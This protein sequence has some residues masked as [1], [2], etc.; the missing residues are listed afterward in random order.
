MPKT[1]STGNGFDK[2][3]FRMHPRVFAALG[4]DLVTN[5]VVAVIELVKNSYDAFAST[6]W[7]RFNKDPSEGD[8]LEI[9]DDGQGMTRKVIEEAWC[10]VAT[11]FKQNNPFVKSGKEQRRVAGQKGLG[12][13]SVARL[14][15]RLHM[16]TQAP[17]D[18]CW[19]V[20]VN[21]SDI[22][23]ENNLS[24]CF[25]SC[26]KFRETSPFKKSGTRLRVFGLRGQW[27]EPRV[28]DLEENLARLISPFSTLGDFYIFLSPPGGEESEEVKILAPDFL[29]KPKYCIRGK[30][31]K[32]GNI[33]ATYKYSPILDG[34]G[35]S[36]GQL[37]SWQQ[38]FDLIKD[39]SRHPF[40]KKR[41]RC[42]MFSFEIRAWDIGP[43]DTQE[44][45]DRFDF[46]KNKVRK[47]IKAHKGI[48]VYRDGILVLPKSEG[49]RDWLGLD[50]RRISKVG[51]RLSTSQLVGYVAISA[52]NNPRIEDTSD[53]ERLVSN[54]SVAEFEELLKKIIE[55]LENER[56]IDRA[57][58]EREKPLEDLFGQLSADKLL[59]DVSELIEEGAD[60]SDAM[61]VLR[62]YSDKLVVARNAIQERFVYYSRMA[63][64]GTIAMMLVHEIR[65]R[66]TAFGSFL[67][68]I[69]S[70]YGPFKDKE[71]K[72]EFQS[73]DESV[74]S[75]ERLA[76][77]FAPL[78]DRGFRR[79]KRHSI[80]EERIRACLR[81]EKGE[82]AQKS[83]DC[84]IPEGET[85]V[86]V[87]P[88]ELDTIIIN[89]ITNATYWL[90][91]KP[92]HKGKI[93][94][95]LSKIEGGNRIRVWVHDNGPGLDDEDK[96]KI[97]WPGFTRKPGGIG[98]GLTVSSELV[99]EYGGHMLIDTNGA[100]GGA[101][102]AFDIPLK[103]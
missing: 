56:D 101:S 49:A 15:D 53:R 28:S 65:T 103:H 69:K 24:G 94:F 79:R 63:T 29:S 10:L 46:K 30:V 5:D 78:A 39:R 2:I 95:K 48:S 81:L 82:I 17:G 23:A 26:R 74:N 97:F 19:E 76:D 41:A 75:L 52:E 68:F 4:A 62:A 12:R 57:K 72:E 61:P 64:V 92:D 98:M 42:G 80:L 7:I 99:A 32:K 38:I 47:A 37:L 73:A 1:S 35:R 34:K 59:A 86:A 20:Q 45:E 51:T 60:A 43:E 27:D 96:E 22:A 18:A 87:D 91:Q 21:W 77:T 100:L 40:S 88:G 8:Y 11:P 89:L 6:A 90:G 85:H 102:F 55:L 33:K 93:E 3:A 16:L 66:T 36:K 31:D 83:I 9:E 71:L 14:G 44:I 13:L 70:R 54:L 67:T 84:R 58:P 50:L 25:V